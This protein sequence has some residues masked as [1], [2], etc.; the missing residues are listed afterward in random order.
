VVLIKNRAVIIKDGI[1]NDL[2]EK[3]SPVPG[4]P[5]VGVPSSPKVSKVDELPM[6][7]SAP[8]PVSV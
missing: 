5:V 7:K 1:S 2:P 6:A 8:P 4:A 3:M